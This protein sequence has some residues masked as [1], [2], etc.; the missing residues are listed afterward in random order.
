MRDENF[1]WMTKRDG[2]KIRQNSTRTEGA[3]ELGVDR[4]RAAIGAIKES[5]GFSS[6]F[7]ISDTIPEL[8]Q[9]H[10]RVDRVD[11]GYSG[12]IKDKWSTQEAK[13][14]NG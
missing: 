7:S 6:G 3:A 12:E 10:R 14:G 2:T 8:I 9:S 11:R 13:T 4:D 5:E 1:N